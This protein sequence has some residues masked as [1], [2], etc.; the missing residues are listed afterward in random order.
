MISNQKK[1]PSEYL[2]L[3]TKGRARDSKFSEVD[4]PPSISG[5]STPRL[6][7]PRLL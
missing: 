2:V 4:F 1:G 3:T 7:S 5:P 6:L